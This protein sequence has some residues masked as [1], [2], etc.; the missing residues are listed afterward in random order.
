MFDAIRSRHRLF[1]ILM[2]SMVAFAFV[3]SGAVGF[4]QFLQTDTSVATV[5]SEKITQQDLE[6]AFRERLDRMAQMLGANFDARA[7]DTPQARAAALDGLLSERTLKVAA[8]KAQVSIGDAK[9][10]DV[11]SSVPSFQREGKFDYNTYQTLLTANGR[12]EHEFEA[13]VREELT[14]QTL[15]DGV[16]A[17]SFLPKAVA[18]MLWQLR[19]ETR[20]IRELVFKP[21][22]YRDQVKVSEEAIQADYKK[23]Q[24]LYMTP[25]TAKVEYLVLR[26]QDLVGKTAIAPEQVRAFYDS[27]LKR[28]GEAERRRASH[29]LIT[30]GAGG[31]APDKDQAKA[32]AQTVLAKLKAKPA[33]FEALAKQYSKDP[34]SAEKGGD[35]GWFGRGMMVK[36]FEQAAFSL[37]SGQTS[38]LVESDFGFHIIRV[39]GIEAA[40]TKSF[41][42]VK[43]QIETE[44]GEQAAQK[45]FSEVAEQFSNFVY[46]QSDGLKTAGDKFK[47]SVHELDGLT[48]RGAPQGEASGFFT[49]ALIEAVFAPDSIAKRRNTKAVEAGANTLVSARVLD[50]H[51][52]AP[53]PLEVVKD[54]IR[55]KLERA[56]ALDLA[57]NAGQARLAQ[58]Q[59]TAD[60]SGFDAPRWVGRSD[61]QQLSPDAINAVMAVDATHLP[62]YVGAVSADGI[63]RVV[64]V[65]ATKAA[66][67]APADGGAEWVRQV[68]SGETVAYVD[69]L[70][71]RFGARVLKSDIAMPKE[72]GKPE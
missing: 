52:S 24:G 23:N 35:L 7:F 44:L 60:D 51:A 56:A 54:S 39:T 14:R 41:E 31:S 53:I 45:R 11:I 67:P 26:A 30:A 55:Q 46:E 65:M 10:Q 18:E 37:A 32:L 13:M 1:M 16:S 15:S 21:D 69:A 6:L 62:S 43:A 40:R 49:P 29:I 20:Q 36:P 71:Q 68:S 66:D 33:D 12:S 4:N 5:G 17:S 2:M 72:E 50:Y 58:L 48:R 22:A 34:G 70:R 8:K 38:E 9:L 42:D 28:W 47:L 19:H 3:L 25:E 27:N 59:K 61:P 63:Y 57:R 64:Q